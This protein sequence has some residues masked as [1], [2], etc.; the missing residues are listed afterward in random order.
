V[1][2]YEFQGP[3]DQLQ[4]SVEHREQEEWERRR[5]ESNAQSIDGLEGLTRKQTEKPV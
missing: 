1:P 5:F 4:R 3:R 2:F